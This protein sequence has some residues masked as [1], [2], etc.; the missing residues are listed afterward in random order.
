MGRAVSVLAAGLLAASNWCFGGGV[1]V[2]AEPKWRNPAKVADAVA[3]K[4][5]EV[6]VDWWGYDPKNST[7]Y[8]QAAIDS[9]AKRVVI[10]K[11]SGPW[12][13]EPLFLRSDLELVLEPG[14]VVEAIA[15]GFKDIND[16]L[17]TAKAKKNIV[18]RGSK[19]STLKM[20]KSDY[21]DKSRYKR[22]EWR[23]AI[24]LMSCENVKILDLT[25]KSSG[26]DGVYVGDNR[27]PVNYCRDIVI[28]NCVID[29][30]NRQGISVISVVNLLIEDCVIKNT[31]GAAP[32]AGIDF[33]PNSKKER[34]FNITV[35]N[36]VLENNAS[37]GIVITSHPGKDTKPISFNFENCRALNNALC[38]YSGGFG[39]NPPMSKIK[40]TMKGCVEV[41]R[42]KKTL[43]N[44][45]WKD[46]QNMQTLTEDE[47]KIAGDLKRVDVR[48]TK[49]KPL[50]AFAGISGEVGVGRLRGASHY[51]LYAAKG[52]EPVFQVKL[53]KR[54]KKGMK[55]TVESPSGAETLSLKVKPGVW[56]DVAF[57]A[58]ETGTYIITCVPQYGAWFS[59]RA[60]K[61]ANKSDDPKKKNETNER[62]NI[63]MLAF[64]KPLHFFGSG[65]NFY[66]VV[67]AGVRNF[68]VLASGE[69]GER[70]KA[71]LYDASDKLVKTQDDINLDYK[72][73]VSRPDASQTE[74][75]RLKTG[76]PSHYY[77]E[78][79]S[80]DLLGVP[81][82]LSR[83]KEC[84]L[85]PVG[86]IGR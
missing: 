42:G 14:V 43:F 22:A 8:L 15:G 9:K 48:K 63:A 83:K 26:G 74:I 68:C 18:I 36:C 17:I 85:E 56:T 3:G 33:E 61:R 54:F 21:H 60:K 23:H 51:I 46:W 25:I 27:K 16:C 71:S 84:L 70:V 1:S 38:G 10:P 4:V 53:P 12:E 11:M 79:Y 37:C 45:F 62:W 58:A 31:K 7:R 77:F 49:L 57:Q 29:D 67:P 28:K 75:W 30:N 47:R 78:D 66:F 65:G 13:T 44:D 69:G 86:E 39:A 73:I 76:R 19:G 55:V 80:I 64:D 72:F 32:Q 41:S 50:K 52:D 81:P 24:K 59:V 20:R 40:A 2:N 6:R 34:L 35:R 5:D 82:I